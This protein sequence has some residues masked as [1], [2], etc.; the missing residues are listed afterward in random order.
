MSAKH[1]RTDDATPAEPL[2]G[3]VPRRGFLKY[4]SAVFAT[5]A[6]P[7]ALSSC[8]NLGAPSAAVGTVAE[9]VDFTSVPMIWVTRKNDGLSLGFRFSGLVS[10][11]NHN[12]NLASGTTAGN[13]YI[14]ITFP[15][16]HVIEDAVLQNATEAL[17]FNQ[18]ASGTSR[19]VFQ[20]PATYGTAADA[21]GIPLVPYDLQGV[22]QLCSQCALTVAGNAMSNAGTTTYLGGLQPLERTSFAQAKIDRVIAKVEPAAAKRVL[23]RLKGADPNIIIRT[24][25]HGTAPVAP[26]NG[27]TSIELPHRLLISPNE[28]MAWSYAT[29]PVTSPEGRTEL[30]NA[31][32]APRNPATGLAD[33]S[34]GGL[35]VRALWTR[36]YDIYAPTSTTA[37]SLAP[38]L[39]DPVANGVLT[40]P[41]RDHL[42]Y[43]TGNMAGNYLP[44][45]SVGRLTLT[46]LG[47]TLDTAAAFPSSLDGWLQA[48]VQRITLGRDEFV[49][50]VTLGYLLPFGHPAAVVNINKRCDNPSNGN[51][52]TVYNQSYLVVGQSLVSYQGLANQSD[53]NTFPFVA[54]ELTQ[55]KIPCINTQGTVSGWVTDPTGFNPSIGVIGTDHKGRAIK[56]KTPLVFVP[57]TNVASAATASLSA[58]TALWNGAGLGSAPFQFEGQRI[59]YASPPSPSSP[60]TSSNTDST[61]FETAQFSI[62]VSPPSV[63]ST[64][65]VVPS[66]SAIT[67]SIDAVR[68]LT[69]STATGTGTPNSTAI[70]NYDTTVYKLQG[71][72][73]TSNPNEVFFTLVAGQ[74]NPPSLVFSGDASTSGALVT[75]DMGITALSRATGPMGGSKALFSSTFSSDFFQGFDP[76]LFGFVPL[77]SIIQPTALL[78]KIV[79][80][81][82][83]NAEAFLQRA[84]ALY[85]TVETA[86]AQVQAL[87]TQAAGDAA[88][89]ATLASGGDKDDAGIAING[90]GTPLTQAEAA[91]YLAASVAA[92]SAQTT[93]QGYVTTFQNLV[94][95]ASTA[96]NDVANQSWS[97]L[98]GTSGTNGDLG[99]LLTD[100]SAVVASIAALKASGTQTSAVGKAAAAAATYLAAI[101]N[102]LA[103]AVSTVQSFLSAAGALLSDLNTLTQGLDL[104]TNISVEFT[105]RPVISGLECGN[106]VAFIPSSPQAL[107]LDIL[108]NSSAVNGQPAGANITCRLD[109]FAI[110][111]GGTLPT[112][113]GAAGTAGTA[114][115]QY[116]TPITNGI[117]NAISGADV[118]LVFDHMQFQSLA[119]QKPD[120]DVVFSNIYFGGDLKFVETLKN[121]LPLDAFSD[122]PF[123]DVTAS[124][125]S[126]GFNLAV[127]DIAVGMFSI[128]NIALSAT[129]TMPFVSTG[130]SGIT[131]EFDF[132]TIDNPFLVTVAMLGG[133]GFFGM[134]MDMSGL[135]R[136]QLGIEVAA[137]L[138]ISLLDIVSGS[139]SIDVGIFLVYNATI[140]EPTDP[141]TGETEQT[142]WLI[143]GYLRLRGELDVAGLITISIELYLQIT[144]DPDT[145]K[146][147]ASGYIQIDV[148]IL[149]FS[150]HAKPSFSRTFAG[151]NGDPTFVQLMGQGTP[152]VDPMIDPTT[153]GELIAASK[154]ANATWDPLLEYCMA[155]V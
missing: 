46:P 14:A 85:Q 147:T 57:G 21:G 45:L 54:V 129:L 105:W 90:G 119:G 36:D 80:Q 140:S 150:L 124:G 88:A 69:T 33:P 4:L 18:Y 2:L 122:P 84:T 98:L 42:V 29:T 67:I 106:M 78:P 149:F 49:E 76:K 31:R 108:V 53:F 44:P 152:T 135:T 43:D 19:L 101:S 17:P 52:G 22:L 61:S 128:E 120:V 13:A 58:A 32:M 38:T 59:A 130:A 63:G 86:S 83:S 37:P 77:T 8:S 64:V 6:L 74:A 51:V 73:P 131:F 100:A 11:A 127:P 111:F 72:D 104:P 113:A 107:S 30:W 23:S 40:P 92:T 132:C 118:T 155:Y 99:T 89:F 143:G 7:E 123:I 109:Q 47:G 71:F 117:Q 82:I 126:A 112:G 70:V 68:H 95:A 24:T 9:D 56:F 94:V 75:P 145:G 3:H 50:T 137:Q 146:C 48:Y 139:V 20:V 97:A 62:V 79:S 25:H 114:L 41:V 154:V 28:T 60:S 148:T 39:V 5:A 144:Y 10:D 141:V 55:T 65:P 151:S 121:L 34:L 136:V 87:V 1:E 103:N 142:G 102:A 15:P 134:K 27:Q 16:Q 116:F 66:A 93:L 133:G 12:L 153:G 91:A 35:T 115:C 26:T 81:E 110:A 138:A 96:A 125:I